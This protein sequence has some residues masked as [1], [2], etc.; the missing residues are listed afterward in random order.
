MDVVVIS[1]GSG[2]VGS[3]LVDAVVARGFRAVVIDNLLTGNPRNL[4]QWD[5]DDRVLVYHQ[6]CAHPPALELPVRYVLHFAS[7]AS[8]ADYLRYPLE[9][10]AAGADGTR[11]M[12]ELARR[13]GAR[14]LLAST[15][16]V[17]GD[18]LVHPQVETYYGNVNPIGPRSVYDEAKRFAESVTMAYHRAL[19]VNTGIVRLFNTYGPRMRLNDGRAIPNFV[20]QAL[21]G[22]PLTLYGDGSMTRSFCYV[23]DTVEGVL[24]LAMSEIHDPVNIG[25]PGEY[26]ILELAQRVRAATGSASPL[27]YA[28]AMQDDP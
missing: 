16:E 14:F 24:R 8:P 6:D 4:A 9:T 23:S 5:G 21:T 27:V 1:G 7:P 17:Y 19:G 11:G 26:T 28:P 20:Y 12:L 2:F 25:N 13:H 15:S 22:Q 3:H 18:P 10:L